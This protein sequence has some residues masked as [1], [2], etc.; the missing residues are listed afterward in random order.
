[1]AEHGDLVG[2]REHLREL[3]GYQHHRTAFLAKTAQDAEESVDLR[4]GEHGGGLVAD[5]HPR[6]P[7]EQA[8][9]LDPLPPSHTKLV[10]AVI[11]REIKPVAGEE[12]L[13]L[14]RHHPPG[15]HPQAPGLRSAEYDVL[16]H[17]HDRDQHEVLVDHPDPVR[18]RDRGRAHRRLAA[19]H[20]DPAPI[21]PEQAIKDAHQGGLAGAV[22]TDEGV[23]RAW[24]QSEINPV[25]GDRITEGARHPLEPHLRGMLLQRAWPEGSAAGAPAAARCA[26]SQSLGISI[27]PATMS[28]SLGTSIRPARIPSR[29]AARVSVIPGVKKLSLVSSRT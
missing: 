9:D 24:S 4:R 15:Q 3:V 21:R 12:G 11:G 18:E 27:R 20:V 6:A 23:D 16:Q 17:R 19:V 28:H 7:V 10:D 8:G 14:S 2:H 26:I 13:E 22:F 29:S 25:V 5:Q 1:M